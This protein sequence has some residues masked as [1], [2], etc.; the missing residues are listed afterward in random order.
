MKNGDGT[1]AAWVFGE[2]V[3]PSPWFIKRFFRSLPTPTMA[4]HFDDIST[5]VA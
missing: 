1:T 5:L 2:A 3:A 4:F